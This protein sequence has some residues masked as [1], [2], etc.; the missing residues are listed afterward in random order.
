MDYVEA[1]NPDGASEVTA[2]HRAISDRLL[3]RESR[4][5]KKVASA[6][7]FL[8][9]QFGEIDLGLLGLDS[10]VERTIKQRI[11]EI[12]IALANHAPLA[13]IFLAG[14]TLEGLLLNAALKNPKSFNQAKAAPL[15]NSG[16][17]RQ[18]PDRTLNN[19][20]NVASETEVIGLDVKKFAHALRGFRNYIHPYQ[21]AQEAFDPDDHTAGISWQVLRAAIADLT[22]K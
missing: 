22:T 3:G 6:A 20:I 17:V 16:K 19:L 2:Q 4:P 7:D 10:G 21:Q 18:F 13:V 14:S 5:Q 8:E 12:Q 1:V 11:D 9:K 15:D